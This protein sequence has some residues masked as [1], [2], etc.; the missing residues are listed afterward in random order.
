MKARRTTEVRR[1][2]DSRFREEVVRM[3]LNGRPVR[4]ISQTLRIGEN[5]IYKWKGRYAGNQLPADTEDKPLTSQGKRT[6]YQ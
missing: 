1:K 4:E 3:V 6:F 2:Y 5:L